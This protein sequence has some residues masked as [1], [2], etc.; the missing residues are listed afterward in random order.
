MEHN[1]SNKAGFFVIVIQPIG[2]GLLLGTVVVAE[3]RTAVQEGISLHGIQYF[4]V[5][6]GLLQY[7]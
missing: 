5:T 2:R 1:C 4:I 6:T 3:I 7:E